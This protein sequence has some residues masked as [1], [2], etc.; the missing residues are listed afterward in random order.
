MVLFWFSF[1][2]LLVAC[3]LLGWLVFISLNAYRKTESEDW[4]A[5]LF[6][7]LSIGLGIIG[8]AAVILA[9][10]G[11]FSLLNLI[12]IWFI[13]TLGLGSW[14]I[15]RR[16]YRAGIGYQPHASHGLLLL[17]LPVA[18]WLMGRPHESIQGGADAGVY[19]S[20]AAHIAQNGAII[21]YDSTLAE[22]EPALAT[23][24]LR[25]LP[26]RNFATHYLFPGFYTSST[27]GEL[28]PQFYPLHPVWQAVAF[29]IGSD[30]IS[31]TYNALR[32]I[33]VWGM[34]GVMAVF[35]TV[36]RM[37]GL[38]A[39]WL[40]LAAL[41]ACALQIWFARYP[42]TE[43]LTQYLLWTGLWAF[44]IWLEGAAQGETRPAWGFLAGL[45]LGSTQLTRIDMFFVWILPAAALLWLLF[46]PSTNNFI[47]RLAPHLSFFVPLIAL[48]AH[49]I[50]HA[51]W[52]SRPYFFDTYGYMFRY[53]GN[54]PALMAIGIIGV[55][56]FFLMGWSWR[57]RVS[58]STR[59]QQYLKGGLALLILAWGVHGWFLRP[60]WEG[61][62]QSNDWYSE[63]ALPILDAINFW[64]LGWYLSPLGVGLGIIAMAWLV[65][66]LERRTLPWLG[67]GLCFSLLYLWRIQ[68]S[69]HQIYTM[70]R[71]VPMVMPF[72]LS[73]A[74]IFLAHWGNFSDRFL[75]PQLRLAQLRVIGVMLLT[76]IWLGNVAMLSRGLVTQVDHAGLTEQLAQFNET[77]PPDALLIFYEPN[78]IGRADFVGTPLYF[79]WGREMV[80]WRDAAALEP[81]LLRQQ[82]V[83]WQEQG[84]SLYWV[85]PPGNVG[86]P[87]TE[88]PLP[89]GH[90]YPL[91]SQALEGSYE[92]RPTV[93]NSIDWSLM[94]VPIP[95]LR[96]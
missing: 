34:L 15:Y 5:Y 70:R 38:G 56:A 25:P 60:A 14:V 12:V 91:M 18:I 86:W 4:I 87:L 75:W 64:R 20:L 37:A 68:A 29:A 9:E 17:W 19:V 22:L 40:A 36:R 78:P 46:R 26:E 10:L 32:L 2:P 28:I 53:I 21:G 80:V 24:F 67:I 57:D 94:V 63:T 77:F 62:R 81:S 71:Y 48:T 45:M 90:L 47:A 30:P 85:A 42:V 51:L 65:T 39:A 55:V 31:G 59:W 76:I 3:T 95:E 72:F 8:W 69:Q 73:A 61:I 16:Y 54:R 52:Q 50:G 43:N 35:L 82:F 11:Q 6:A 84:R 27:P 58:L 88:T 49:S 7:S 79:I 74:A 13:L 93:I 89:D 92:Y 1:L 41:T 33:G 44:I 23:A 66:H 96:K 83:R